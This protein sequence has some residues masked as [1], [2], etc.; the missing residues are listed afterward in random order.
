[1]TT[2]PHPHA[3]RVR[4][5]LAAV[6]LAAWAVLSVADALD[7]VLEVR[8]AYLNVDDGVFLLHARVQYPLNPTIQSALRDGITLTYDLDTR[9]ERERRFWFDADVVDL[10]LRRELSYH[11]VTDR[12]LVRDTR[13]GKQDSFATTRGG[14]GIPRPGGRV[15]NTRRTAARRRQLSRQRAR[16]GAS[17]QHAFFTSHAAVLDRRLA[18][19]KRVVLMVAAGMNW[20]RFGLV[21]LCATIGASALLLLAKSAQN[22]S[23]F[24]RLQL[25]ILLLNFI[26]VF[27]LTALLARKIW[28]LVR[29]YR[30]HVPGSR[31]TARTVAIFG[32]LVVA[33]LLI[34]YLFSLEF[35]NRGIDSWFR[36]EVKEELNTALVLSR[37]ALDARMREYS[38]RTEHLAR[39]LGEARDEGMSS[40]VDEARRQSGAIEVV[41]FGEHER[42]VAASLENAVET[43]PSRPP[44][45]LIRQVNQRRVYM[46]PDPEAGGLYL[47]RT[48]A[49]LSEDPT[50]SDNR[51]VMA[52]YKVPPQNAR[53]SEAV[54]ERVLAI[55][56]SRGAARAAQEQ[57]PADADPGAA[58]RDACGDPRRDLFGP[59]PDAARAGSDRRHARRRQG[60]FRHAAAAAITRRDGISGAFFQR[61]DQAP[62]ARAR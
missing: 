14:A 60:R 47:I 39:I 24:G 34:V 32:A 42:I 2:A 35:L 7:G 51:Y 40:Q 61:H 56:Q 54:Q 22:S 33:P 6:F 12:Y 43:L 5:M 55:R 58:Y 10:T 25:W 52:V 45:D 4:V 59:A 19:S 28:H 48:A 20:R 13:S 53:L 1:M 3:S 41:V 38:Q 11:A 50:S 46:A 31:L 9:I 15:A 29:E 37:E 16:R 27:A 18:S 8:S 36:A 30:N 26:G 62:A 49:P 21:L 57:L 23:E 17:R 44:S